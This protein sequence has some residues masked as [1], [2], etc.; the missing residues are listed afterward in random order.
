MSGSVIKIFLKYISVLF[1]LGAGC[2]PLGGPQKTIIKGYEM[3]SV[4]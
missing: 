3:V 4:E 2:C 1:L